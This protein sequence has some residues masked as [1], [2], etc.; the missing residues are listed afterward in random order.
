MPFPSSILQAFPFYKLAI[1]FT[2]KLSLFTLLFSSIL[3]ASLSY[4]GYFRRPYDK[5]SLPYAILIAYII[6]YPF[7]G[8]FLPPY[9]TL[10]HYHRPSYKLH[11]PRPF[12][13]SI[14]Y[15]KLTL[16]RPFPSSKIQALL[17]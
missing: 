7:L 12:P 16:P 6:I 2:H 8:Q 14:L 5:L 11:L 4:I 10:S 1:Y 15:Y 13:S 9:Y 3:Q 17:S